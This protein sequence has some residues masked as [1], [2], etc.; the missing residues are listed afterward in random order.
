MG[1]GAAWLSKG[2][3][4]LRE[5]LLAAQGARWDCDAL[6]IGSG[7]GGAV[8][9]ARLAGRRID[10][11]RPALGED[12]VRRPCH[13]RSVDQRAATEAAADQHADIVADA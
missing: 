13:H 7:Y 5:R 10:A 3:E 4:S 1:N 8:A 12:A 9:A 11:G 2:V 6:I